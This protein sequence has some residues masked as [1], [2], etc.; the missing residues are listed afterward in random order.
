MSKI[1]QI[2][3]IYSKILSSLGTICLIGIMMYIVLSVSVRYITGIPF[4]GSYE[5]GST[6]LPLIAASYYMYADIKNRHIRATIFFDRFGRKTKIFL[7]F[8]FSLISSGII[9]MVS[10]RVALFGVR[11]YQNLDET[12]VLGLRMDLFLFVYSFLLLS[13]AIY[14]FFK[15][16]DSLKGAPE[17]VEYSEKF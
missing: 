9:L 4:L 6:F 7:L 5:L 17:V 16:I 10:W 12:S 2:F 13:Y 3:D 1:M 8:M 14:L 15:A 11:A